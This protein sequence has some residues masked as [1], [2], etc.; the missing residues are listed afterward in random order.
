[1]K[2]DFGALWSYLAIMREDLTSTSI[3]F[4]DWVR[5]YYFIITQ[6]LNQPSVPRIFFMCEAFVLNKI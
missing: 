1:M 6:V 2:A 4:K 5:I 3:H